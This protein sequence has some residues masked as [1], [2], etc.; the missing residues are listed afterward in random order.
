MNGWM[1]TTRRINPILT[2]RSCAKGLRN[3]P[4]FSLGRLYY[5]T[6][7]ILLSASCFC[8]SVCLCST[9]RTSPVSEAT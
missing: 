9:L 2:V 1:A 8:A 4:P 6:G 5:T 3:P 7:A